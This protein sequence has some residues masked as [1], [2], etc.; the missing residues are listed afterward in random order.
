MR[1]NNDN[2]KY[3]ISRVDLIRATFQ[4]YA[5]LYQKTFISIWYRSLKNC[6]YF[7]KNKTINK[8]MALLMLNGVPFST[9]RLLCVPFHRKFVLLLNRIAPEMSRNVR[10]RTCRR[11]PNEDSNQPAH[12]RSLISFFIARM[13]NLH[14]WLS[15]MCP[16]KILIRLRE[17]AG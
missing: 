4:R 14:P 8:F 5:K 2:T 16:V 9:A 1:E 15:K 7:H 10:K 17:C 6:Q 11:A 13:K 3:H 12:P